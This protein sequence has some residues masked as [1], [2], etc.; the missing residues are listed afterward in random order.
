MS[1]FTYTDPDEF[2]PETPE[3]VRAS[4]LFEIMIQQRQRIDNGKT[5]V[6]T[7]KLKVLFYL[8]PEN[9]SMIKFRI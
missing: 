4:N 5:V 7:L 3:L 1:G 6:E 9:V 8:L 2:H